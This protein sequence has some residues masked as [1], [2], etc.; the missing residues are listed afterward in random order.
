MSF[1]SF[2]QYHIR[3]I[4]V[5]H[6]SAFI[7]FLKFF[8]DYR[9]VRKYNL[10]YFTV[11]NLGERIHRCKVGERKKQLQQKYN[12]LYDNQFQNEG[13]YHC[14]MAVNELFKHQTVHQII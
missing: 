7:L 12:K 6:F 5:T 8:S 14:Y 9:E 10:Y 2:L 11:E 13:N 1:G 3:F 4:T